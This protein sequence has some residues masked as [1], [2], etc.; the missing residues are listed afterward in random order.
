MIYS[1][2]TR[3]FTAALSVFR[4]T[5]PAK[6]LESKF[7]LN[8]ISALF[9]DRRTYLTGG[10]PRLSRPSSVAVLLG[11]G[12]HPPWHHRKRW[13]FLRRCYC[14]GWTPVLVLCW[15]T[16][17]RC[18]LRFVHR[19]FIF[20]YR[21]RPFRENKKPCL[22]LGKQGGK[23]I[24]FFYYLLTSGLSKFDSGACPLYDL[25]RPR[26]NTQPWLNRL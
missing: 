20:R 23:I 18:R 15:L 12:A 3:G 9:C 11:P 14:G 7:W 13:T 26:L 10:E 2:P 24:L 25:D 16:S 5:P 21:F 22:L 19:S 6:P 1:I 4:G 17:S 8:T